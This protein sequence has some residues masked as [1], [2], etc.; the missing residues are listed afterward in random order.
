M[1]P[2]C[3]VLFVV[4]GAWCSMVLR[5][6]PPRRVGLRAGL[7]P[8]GPVRACLCLSVLPVPV[9]SSSALPALPLLGACERGGVELPA[10]D[11]TCHCGGCL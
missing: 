11:S 1:G 8:D 2:G 4:A 9:L 6:S 5:A 10:A 7:P 3:V